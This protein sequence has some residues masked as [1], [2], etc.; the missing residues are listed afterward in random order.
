MSYKKI[1]KEEWFK[2]SQEERDYYTLEFNKSIE[3]RKK[4]TILITRTIAVALIFV[5]FWIGFVQF[6]AV[7]NY[8]EVIDE[9]GSDG[10]CYLCGELALKKCECQYFESSFILNHP[11][12]FEN[13]STDLAIS[14]VKK[15]SS[16]KV[17]ENEIINQLP[18]NI[19]F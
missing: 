5:L 13:Y 19:S 14:N 8:N 9:Y 17:N 4:L 12:Y 10:Y 18:S 7:N 11:E 2:L 6:K 16:L 15:C 3:K 1:S